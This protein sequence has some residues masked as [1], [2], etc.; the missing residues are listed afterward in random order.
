VGQIVSGG[1]LRSVLAKSTYQNAPQGRS[2]PI[3]TSR[4]VPDVDF[5]L[6]AGTGALVYLSLPPDGFSAVICGPA[7]CSTGW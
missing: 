6:S 3:G 2:T 1:R 7:P 5:Q 4:G